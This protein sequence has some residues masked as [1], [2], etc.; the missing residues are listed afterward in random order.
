MTDR[1]EA[2][3]LP[4]IFLTVTLL[5][6][7]RVSETIRLIPPSLT[8]L[9]LAVLLIGTIFRGGALAPYALLHGARSGMEN[10]S[11]SSSC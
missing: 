9:I 3:V 5:G 11:G 4:A 10:V 6:G 1:R 2:L 7:F 8:A